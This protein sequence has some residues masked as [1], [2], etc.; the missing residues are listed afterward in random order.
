[1]GD[2]KG[3]PKPSRQ[4]LTWVATGPRWQVIIRGMP[5]RVTLRPVA[6]DPATV[7]LVVVTVLA[8]PLAINPLPTFDRRNFRLN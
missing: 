5:T 4:Q 3:I 6:F 8:A 1:M 7:I 2:I